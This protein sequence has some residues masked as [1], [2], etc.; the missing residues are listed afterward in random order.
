MATKIY[1]ILDKHL[2][3]NERYSYR[4]NLNSCKFRIAYPRYCCRV[5]NSCCQRCYPISGNLS[6]CWEGSRQGTAGWE[7]AWSCGGFLLVVVA[8]IIIFFFSPISRS[9][10]KDTFQVKIL[11]GTFGSISMRHATFSPYVNDIFIECVRN[12]S[13]KN[14]WD[15][16]CLFVF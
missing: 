6:S 16:F 7:R 9:R 14:P 4:S 8:K 13:I 1:G 3:Q 5:L 11:T 12:A 10:Y 15:F 2:L